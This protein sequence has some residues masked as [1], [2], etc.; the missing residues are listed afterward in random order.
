[1]N[2]A[3]LLPLAVKRK[4]PSFASTASINAAKSLPEIE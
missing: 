4:V 1:M 2:G 3:M